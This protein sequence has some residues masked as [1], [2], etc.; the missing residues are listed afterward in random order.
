[1][2]V[3]IETFFCPYC[4]EATEIYLRLVNTILFADNENSM[5]KLLKYVKK[6]VSQQQEEERQATP[7]VA[8]D[9]EEYRPLTKA[10]LIADLNEMCEEVKLIRA[11][12]LKG[13]TW[14]DFKHELHR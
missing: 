9:T 14:E 1:M 11:G 5:R 6:L 8:E 12:K 13:Q 7:V 4:D 3:T 2:K 10:E